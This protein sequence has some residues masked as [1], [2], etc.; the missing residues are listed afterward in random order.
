M[1]PHRSR[2]TKS[3]D[4]SKPEATG[5][6]THRGHSNCPA[7]QCRH[8]QLKRALPGSAA[9]SRPGRSGSSKGT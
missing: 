1:P 3:A 5:T 7:P 2:C 6:K 8:A 4:G 9:R